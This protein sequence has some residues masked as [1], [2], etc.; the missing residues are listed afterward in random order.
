MWSR[1]RDAASVEQLAKKSP[2]KLAVL[3][4]DCRVMKAEVDEEPSKTRVVWEVEDAE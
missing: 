3:P 2:R 4:D 1:I